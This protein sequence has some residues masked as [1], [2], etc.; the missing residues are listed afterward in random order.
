MS[1]L[2]CGALE[3]KKQSCFG[4]NVAHST[5]LLTLILPIIGKYEEADMTVVEPVIAAS[6][7]AAQ[8]HQEMDEAYQQLA[9]TLRERPDDDK[10]LRGGD[11]VADALGRRY[12]RL[13]EDICRT[14]AKTFEGVLAKLQCATQCIWDILPNG[15]DPEQACDIELR[16]VFAVERD[17]RRL[18]ANARRNINRRRPAVTPG[19]RENRL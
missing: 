1:I 18:I 7:I 9:E 8:V 17:V 2:P 6:K 3:E 5:C 13:C 16:F 12:E 4:S 10:A 14:E 15:T 19:N 11:A